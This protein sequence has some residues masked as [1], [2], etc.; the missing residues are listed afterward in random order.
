MDDTERAALATAVKQLNAQL[1][2]LMEKYRD[3]IEIRPS[4][5]FAV[6]DGIAEVVVRINTGTAV[7][8]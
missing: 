4:V 6:D 1:A 2:T 8:R 5:N 3:K 7:F